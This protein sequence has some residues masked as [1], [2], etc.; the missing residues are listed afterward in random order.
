MVEGEWQSSAHSSLTDFSSSKYQTLSNQSLIEKTKHCCA[1][2]KIKFF[3]SYTLLLLDLW[4]MEERERQTFM[5]QGEA[6]D[7]TRVLRWS[8][9]RRLI[10]TG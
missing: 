3:M 4:D 8:L 9:T 1:Q 10:R 6:D 5:S 7:L 2:C